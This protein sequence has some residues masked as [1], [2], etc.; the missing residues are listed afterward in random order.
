MKKAGELMVP[1]QKVITLSPEDSLE[2]AVRKLARARVSGAPVVVGSE[3]KVVGVLSE[4]DIL[5]Y[6][7]RTEAEM[8]GEKRLV[9]IEHMAPTRVRDLMSKSPVTV[10]PGAGLDEVVE[11]MT[12]KKVNR[13]VVVDDKKSLHGLIARG[14]VLRAAEET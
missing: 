7:E 5:R 14:D 11:L 12:A 2:G 13:V 3:K 9:A 6:I 8:G 4:S 10:G 1:R